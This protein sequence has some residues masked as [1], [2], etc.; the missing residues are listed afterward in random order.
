[1]ISDAAS[2]VVLKVLIESLAKAVGV[3]ERLRKLLLGDS[4]RKALAS[5]VTAVFKTFEHEDPE[6]ASSL[7]DEWFLN[8]TAASLLATHFLR[9]DD[10]TERLVQAWAAS[11]PG[12]GK[13]RGDAARSYGMRIARFLEILD[14]E[15]RREPL[16]QQAFDRSAWDRTAKAAEETAK[17]TRL[18][19]ETLERL[20]QHFTERKTI[21][22]DSPPVLPIKERP[23]NFVPRPETTDPLLDRLCKEADGDHH[24]VV[25][26]TA[27]HGLGGMGK[28]TVAAD[29]I[30]RPEIEARFPDGRIRVTLGRETPD[31]LSTL[32]DNVLRPLDP[33]LLKPNSL[34]EAKAVLADLLAERRIL[35]VIDDVWDERV[36][37]PFLVPAAIGCRWLITTRLTGL[38]RNIDSEA[39]HLN[40][41]SLDEHSN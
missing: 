34:T 24:G 40:Q 36:V 32:I 14:E 5:R 12:T 23:K 13:S 39:V 22:S 35:I 4:A 1:M 33:R 31:V 19:A 15:M 25:A 20:M 17:A 8:E 41:M 3:D 7:F 37:E 26:I 6:L 11:L 16:Y 27:V 10:S 21:P 38:A 28:T 9:L 29:L 18:A 30:W 2:A